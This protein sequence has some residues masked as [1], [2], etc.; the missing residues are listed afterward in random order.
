V[1]GRYDPTVEVPE[2]DCLLARDKPGPEGWRPS[3]ERP[4][5]LHRPDCPRLAAIHRKYGLA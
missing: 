5:S 4:Y 3:P 2:C 1:K